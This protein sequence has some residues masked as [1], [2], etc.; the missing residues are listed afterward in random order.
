MK[1][2]INL[3]L[4]QATKLMVAL[5]EVSTAN[6]LIANTQQFG[7]YTLYIKKNLVSEHVLMKITE[8]SKQHG[9]MVTCS[10]SHYIIV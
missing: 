8:I 5:S 10:D 6:I 4:T 7:G 1:A 2:T 9:S 3:D